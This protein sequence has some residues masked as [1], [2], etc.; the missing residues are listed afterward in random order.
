MDLPGILREMYASTNRITFANAVLTP[1]IED[2]T[3]KRKKVFLPSD[4][5][6]LKGVGRLIDKLAKSNGLEPA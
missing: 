6:L 2:V 1:I 5:Q 3:S 4:E